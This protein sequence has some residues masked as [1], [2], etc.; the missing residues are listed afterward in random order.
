MSPFLPCLTLICVHVALRGEYVHLYIPTCTL[1]MAVFVTHSIANFGCCLCIKIHV[2]MYMYM[3]MKKST[4]MVGSYKPG[5]YCFKLVSPHQLGIHV[6]LARHRA[7]YIY[8]VSHNDC[9]SVTSEQQATSLPQTSALPRAI[10]PAS[11]HNQ[12]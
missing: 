1:I 2:M 10:K 7:L 11:A 12:Q 5:Q 9:G 3:Y 8:K 6:G 4:V